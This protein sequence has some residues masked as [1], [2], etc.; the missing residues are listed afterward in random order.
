MCSFLITSILEFVIEYVNFYNK[1]RGPDKTNDII[2]NNIRFIH[3]LLHIT[4]NITIQ[5]FIDNNICCL[6]NGEIYNYKTFGDYNSDGECL[7]PL[8]KKYGNEFI[9]RLDGEFAIVLFDFNEDKFIISTDVFSTKPLWYCIEDGQFGISSYKSCLDRLNF[10]KPLKLTANTTLIYSISNLEK[11]DNTSVFNFNLNQ[12]KLTY[13]DWLDAF[14]NSVDKRTNNDTYPYYVC[15]SSGYDS[16][17]ICCMLNKLNKKYYTYT[18]P[19]HENMNVLKQR[20][21]LNNNNCI[22]NKIVNI[23]TEIFN[24][25]KKYILNNAENFIYTIPNNGSQSSIFNDNA[26]MGVAEICKIASE[27]KHR[28]YLSGQGADE[29]TSDYGYQGRKIY[30]HSQFG[31]LFPENLESIFPWIS[32][33]TG[34][35]ESYLAK[36]EHISGLYGIEGRY[37]FLDKY[38]VQ[39]FLWLHQDLKNKNY[40]AP[41]YELMKQNKYKFDLE[42]K[43]GFSPL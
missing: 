43:I 11:I 28:I 34:S 40:K 9:K 35:Q 3:N 16:G 2:L 20:F 36:E 17:S 32:F 25:N 39:E 30:G 26:A 7:I 10:K 1:F 38:V 8:Y 5:P 22:D 41:L 18:I 33:Y 27:N 15:L 14:K 12:H 31:G 42:K 6:Y 21:M 13:S 29:I 37:P 4:G 24:N 23:N 19:G